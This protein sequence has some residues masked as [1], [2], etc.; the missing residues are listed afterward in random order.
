MNVS[1]IDLPRYRPISPITFANVNKTSVIDH[2][3]GSTEYD[4]D[5]DGLSG[6]E[7]IESSY[8]SHK[9][10][11]RT[12][13]SHTLRPSI[14]NADDG[15]QQRNES[16]KQLSTRY[17]LLTFSTGQILEDEFLLSWYN[18]RPYE[19]LEL[20][21]AGAVVGLPREVMLDYVKPYFMAKVKAL[22][23]EGDLLY[24]GSMR[25][26]QAGKG[27][28]YSPDTSMRKKG[29]IK[30]EWKERWV[31]IHQGV[32]NL[33]KY[34]TVGVVPP[35]H[36]CLFADI[37]IS[38]TIR[39]QTPSSAFLS[40]LSVRSGA[41]STS[42]GCLRLSL[43]H[44]SYVLGSGQCRRVQ[45]RRPGRPR[46]HLSTITGK[47]REVEEWAKARATTGGIPEMMTQSGLLWT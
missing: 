33:C 5:S 4:G 40:P 30:L 28:S 6:F 27:Q 23:K 8:G 9:L 7:A 2:I 17:T 38:I 26:Q 21:L 45:A 37:I 15:Q 11:P 16:T 14:S 22:R 42:R 34:R 10:R 47:W 39:T 31:I 32:L 20:H 19:L 24:E 12:A 44:A 25:I 18:L 1:D 46:R 36:V 43:T 35:M 13:G 3:D 29:K 41:P